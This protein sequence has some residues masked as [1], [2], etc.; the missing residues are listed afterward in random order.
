[1]K[2]RI[3]TYKTLIGTID[4][5]DLGIFTYGEWVIYEKGKPKYHI[6]CFKENSKSDLMVKSLIESE[7]LSIE[8]IIKCINKKFNRQQLQQ[9][10]N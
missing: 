8:S 5:L 4:Y 6:S 3:D 2:Y 7:N 9:Q 10:R 1:M